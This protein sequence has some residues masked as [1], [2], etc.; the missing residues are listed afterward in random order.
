MSHLLHPLLLYVRNRWDEKNG[1]YYSGRLD[2][3][4]TMIFFASIFCYQLVKVAFR[5]FIFTQ[6]LPQPSIVNQRYLDASGNSSCMHPEWQSNLTSSVKTTF[7][8]RYL[9]LKTSFWTH[10]GVGHLHSWNKPNI[11]ATDVFSLFNRRGCSAVVARSLC[12]W[13]APGSIPGISIANEFEWVT[14]WV[15]TG[16]RDSF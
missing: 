7:W 6:C 10:L 8:P 14:G 15:V 1:F 5:I 13:K 9:Y 2:L 11:K 16:F 12:M 3:K 4:I